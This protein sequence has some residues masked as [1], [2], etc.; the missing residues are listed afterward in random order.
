MQQERAAS[1]HSFCLEQGVQI[2][3]LADYAQCYDDAFTQ[4]GFLKQAAW[5]N[6]PY[7]EGTAIFT[8]DL[9]EGTDIPPGQRLEFGVDTRAKTN[10]EFTGVQKDIGG[11]LVFATY[12]RSGRNTALPIQGIADPNCVYLGDFN[13]ASTKA[14]SSLASHFVL[15][16]GDDRDVNAC[17]TTRKWRSPFSTQWEKLEPDATEKDFILVP[18][19]RD[20]SLGAVGNTE[21]HMLKGEITTATLIPNANHFSDH[22]II[23]RQVGKHKLAVLNMAFAQEKPLEFRHTSLADLGMYENLF[24][25]VPR[26]YATYCNSAGLLEVP[27]LAKGEP[28]LFIASPDY[29][30][31]GRPSLSG[32]LAEVEKVI[33][34]LKAW[35]EEGTQERWEARWWEAVQQSWDAAQADTTKEE[36]FD[37]SMFVPLWAYDKACIQAVTDLDSARA[38]GASVTSELEIVVAE[39]RELFGRGGDGAAGD[40]E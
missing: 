23:T 5:S 4:Q 14:R 13:T 21:V 26:L 20:A 12:L 22:F 38:D 17:P 29:Y 34:F 11:L 28:S 16:G 2:L 19:R 35:K 27:A 6:G 15:E 33:T 30:H 3:C 10:E 24:E 32:R 36:K 8:L 18:R 31:P 37:R 9:P 40:G 39:W 1:I 7:A 25:S